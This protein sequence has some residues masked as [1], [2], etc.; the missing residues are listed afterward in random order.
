MPSID[1]GH[2]P[3]W[4][5]LLIAAVAVIGF[6]LAVIGFIRKVW[7]IVTRFVRTVNSLAELPTFIEDSKEFREETK[8]TL[9]QQDE[10]IAEIHHETHK[11][12]GSSIKDSTIRSE[13]AI[14]RVE[15]GVKGL[16]DRLELTDAAAAQMRRDI[17]DTRPVT[18]R[19][20]TTKPPRS[21]T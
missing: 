2:A 10:K 4:L 11:N 9:A 7:P 6:I 13:E 3:V 18:P 15:L 20:R 1:Y 5:Q 12:D 14:E 17:E 21:T 16:Y 8:A 19:K